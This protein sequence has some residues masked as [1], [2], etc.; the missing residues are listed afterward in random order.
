MAKH[1]IK[2][3]A[4]YIGS[5]ADHFLTLWAHPMV[6]DHQGE[7]RADYDQWYYRYEYDSKDMKYLEQYRDE[8][9]DLSQ[10]VYI[11]EIV[12]KGDILYNILIPPHVREDLEDLEKRLIHG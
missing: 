11:D 10:P 3:F 7:V 5:N 2:G 8:E 9:E 12:M 1:D 4:C 6:E